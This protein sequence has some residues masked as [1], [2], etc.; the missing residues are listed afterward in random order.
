ML[1]HPDKVYGD[2][3]DTYRSLI[4]FFFH[5]KA[6]PSM[7]QDILE[8]MEKA[9]TKEFFGFQRIFG[10]PKAV[11]KQ[12]GFLDG[13]KITRTA[14]EYLAPATVLRFLVTKF[15]DQWSHQWQ[16]NINM[17]KFFSAWPKAPSEQ[18]DDPPLESLVERLDAI[19]Q[20]L[21]DLDVPHDLGLGF[22]EKALQ[23]SYNVNLKDCKLPF[24]RTLLWQ[25]AEAQP[26]QS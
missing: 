23:G 22:L 11:L 7:I 1:A 19:K 8:M 20:S 26:P 6:P 3:R 4:T 18:N 15:P 2:S 16:Q 9:D 17:D 12:V 24:A 10:P 21:K 14:C 5:L 13:N 25:S